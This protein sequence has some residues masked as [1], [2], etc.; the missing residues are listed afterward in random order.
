MEEELLKFKTLYE[1]ECEENEILKKQFKEVEIAY[2]NR[3]N[4]LKKANHNFVY[5]T[6]RKVY[7]KVI[8]R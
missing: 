3:I 6:L 8:K 1:I 4:E 7:K 2:E 5:K